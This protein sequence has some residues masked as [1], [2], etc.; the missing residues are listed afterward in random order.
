M[1]TFITEEMMSRS[2]HEEI[3]KNK[4]L[5]QSRLRLLELL[6]GLKKTQKEIFIK[7]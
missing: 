5:A 3:S 1:K 6:G 2:Q 7:N 4:E